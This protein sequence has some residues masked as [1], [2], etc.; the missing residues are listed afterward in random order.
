MLEQITTAV[1]AGAVSIIG[2]LV[3]WLCSRV[4][5]K[6]MQ[7]E[8]S[9]IKQVMANSG[10]LYYVECPECHTR[11]ILSR[12][13]IGVADDNEKKQDTLQDVLQQFKSLLDEAVNKLAPVEKK[14]NNGGIMENQE[15]S[16]D[17]KREIELIAQIRAS[18]DVIGKAMAELETMHANMP[19]ATEESQEAEKQEEE[20]KE[21][22]QEDGAKDESEAREIDEA[23]EE[24]KET[25]DEKSEADDETKYYY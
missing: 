10:K 7:D 5:T 16:Y 12:A 8:I 24:V 6:A 25:E 11:I 3:F 4:R 22:R 2:T 21:E 17:E 13:K 15:T 14:N 18:H 20:S 23:E 9:S 19:V 1:I